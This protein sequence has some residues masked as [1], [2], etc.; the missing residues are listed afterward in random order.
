MIAKGLDFDN[1]T[2]VGIVNGDTGLFLPDFR[3]GEKVFQLLYQAAGRSG[4][5]RPGEVIIQTYNPDN[6]VLKHAA[7]LDQKTY[8]NIALSERQELNYPPFSWM[9]RI[10]IQGIKKEHVAT[11]AEKIKRKL[12][13]SPRGIEILG[14]AN[15]YRERLRGKYRMHIMLKSDKAHD[16]NGKKLHDYLQKRMS[17]KLFD[18][19]PSSIKAFVDVNPMSVL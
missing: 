2:L 6:P 12:H 4:R 17:T 15:C 1:V 9:L 18:S 8:Y 5:R 14:P 10:E 13:P 3:S 16:S 7:K 19:L 11:H